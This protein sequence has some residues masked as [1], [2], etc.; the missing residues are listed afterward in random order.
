MSGGKGRTGALNVDQ[1]NGAT[2]RLPTGSNA[3][4]NRVPVVAK[5]LGECPGHDEGGQV[6]GSTWVEVARMSVVPSPG[7]PDTGEPD[8]VKAA[9]P[10]REGGVGFPAR[11]LAFYFIL[12]PAC[13]TAACY[14]DWLALS[15][16]E[17]RSDQRSTRPDRKQDMF[18]TV[19]AEVHLL[20]TA[21]TVA[22]DL[23]IT[24]LLLASDSGSRLT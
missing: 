5:R 24:A 16:R 21:R 23:P 19:S 22:S 10:V 14:A 3:H 13:R 2:T 12:T 6:E 1:V 9:C 17:D 8:A 4:G 18:A 20:G 7:E 15:G 11:G